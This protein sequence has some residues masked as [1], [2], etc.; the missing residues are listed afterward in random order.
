[1]K[2]VKTF[3]V[4]AAIGAAIASN[5]QTVTV[6]PTTLTLGFMNWSA[7]PGDAAGYGGYGNSSW[8]LSALQANFSG[9]A[10]TLGPNVNTYQ[11][12]NNYWVNA[13][14]SGANL[15]DA[16]IYNETTGVYVNTLLTFTYDVAA[17]TFASPYT[18]VAFIKDFTPSYSSFIES[19]APLAPGLGSITLLTSA[20]A[21]DHIQYGFETKGPDTD[22][23]SP[24]ASEFATILPVPE[25][26]TLSLIGVGLFGLWRSRCRR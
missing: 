14:G 7:E 10:L 22:P 4:C 8:G 17:D 1:M 18:S 20:N 21:G 24:A 2:T 9:S 16:N 6:D 15:M 13:D 19:T 3:V 26:G 23:N 12:G 5:A 25:P 11:P